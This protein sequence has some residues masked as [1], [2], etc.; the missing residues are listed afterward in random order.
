MKSAFATP[1]SAKPAAA[2]STAYFLM[3][4]LLKPRYRT[5]SV[6]NPDHPGSCILF[7]DRQSRALC[8]RLRG[9][10]NNTHRTLQEKFFN[11]IGRPAAG[12]SGGG[13]PTVIP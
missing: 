6:R 10:V 13:A 1:V 2:A 4:I 5:L 8:L 9:H 3:T 12:F 11:F 7:V